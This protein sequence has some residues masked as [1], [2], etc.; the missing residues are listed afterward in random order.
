[1]LLNGFDID[2]A[3]GERSVELRVGDFPALGI[4]VDLLVVSA[5]E[6]GYE[7]VPGTLLGRLQEAYGLTIGQLPVA[8]DLRASPLRCWVSEAIDWGDRP[9]GP[10][11]SGDISCFRRIAVVE[12]SF[13]WEPGDL[14]PWPPFNRLFSLLAL[15]PLRQIPSAVVATPLLGSGDQGIDPLLHFPEL[16][17]AYREAFRHVPDLQR[18]ILFD[19]TDQAL[20]T[21][22]EAID[23]AL[24]RPDGQSTRLQLPS[25]LPGLDRLQWLLRETRKAEGSHQASS[26]SQDLQELLALLQ[27]PEISPIALGIH[28]RRVVEQLVQQSLRKD[29]DLPVRLYSGIHRL[30]D[31]NVDPWVISCLH[32][33]RTFGNWMSHPQAKGRH[34]PVELP[35]VLA[36]LAALHRALA[37][38]PWI[39]P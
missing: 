21:L 14:L 35:D 7:P 23:A 29:S 17:H 3:T 31:Q 20:H 26:L 38:Y 13:A 15:L 5:F 9:G 6:G 16:L 34:R 11:G 18:L 4:T 37:D 1:M 8:L 28:C 33:V 12:G 19:K 30:R 39:R 24:D 27:S 32:Q 36:M 10:N 25:E 2:T 22:G